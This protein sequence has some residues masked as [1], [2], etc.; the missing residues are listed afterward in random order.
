MSA[1]GGLTVETAAGGIAVAVL[2]NTAAKAGYAAWRG[3][4]E[5]RKG[6]ALILGAS[7][8]AGVIAILVMGIRP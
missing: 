2:A 3:A 1:G 4:P 8:V 6:V 5:Y 7:F